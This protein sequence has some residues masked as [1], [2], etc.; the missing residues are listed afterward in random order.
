MLWAYKSKI[1]ILY[2][3]LNSRGRYGFVFD[4]TE[5]TDSKDPNQTADDVFL[6]VTG[7]PEWDFSPYD[8]NLPGDISGWTRLA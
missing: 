4:D 3:R 5:Y 7:C 2:I 1:G 6:K 8:P